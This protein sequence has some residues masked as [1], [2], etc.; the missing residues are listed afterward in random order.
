[1]T[2]SL[3]TPGTLLD[4]PPPPDF[5]VPWDDLDR[6][7]AWVRRLRAVPQDARHH[8]EGDVW[9]HTRLVCEA[10]TSGAAW[11]GLADGEARRIVDVHVAVAGVGRRLERR[12]FGACRIGH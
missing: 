4:P 11:R 6:A 9:I 5:T 1:M 8:A 7:F 10:L 12:R 3:L 2:D